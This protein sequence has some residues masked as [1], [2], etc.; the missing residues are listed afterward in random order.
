MVGRTEST[1]QWHSLLNSDGS[2]EE[3]CLQKWTPHGQRQREKL[4]EGTLWRVRRE[5]GVCVGCVGESGLDVFGV[6]WGGMMMTT[7]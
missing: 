5:G 3:G 6:L 1:Y 7:F 2:W 4:A